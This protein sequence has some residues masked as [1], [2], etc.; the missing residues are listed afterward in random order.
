[1]TSQDSLRRLTEILRDD[2]QFNFS[3][4]WEEAGAS[5]TFKITH[6]IDIYN[7]MKHNLNDDFFDAIYITDSSGRILFPSKDI[8]LDLFDQ[9]QF[10][11]EISSPNNGESMGEGEVR[12]PNQVG[13]QHFRLNISSVEQEI[14]ST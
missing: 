14:F 12:G 8:G 3:G 6:A 13:N 10:R 2:P 7:L 1:K 11:G 9:G 4:S 5:R